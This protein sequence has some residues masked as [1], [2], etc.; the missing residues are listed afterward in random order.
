MIP[1]VDAVRVELAWTGWRDVT[2]FTDYRPG[3]SEALFRC[4]KTDEL[5]ERGLAEVVS[6]HRVEP[7]A[8]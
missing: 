7:P 3:S 8:G 5:D 1:T 6:P 4:R 2:R